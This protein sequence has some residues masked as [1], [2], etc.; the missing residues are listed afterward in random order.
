MDATLW[1][2]LWPHEAPDG[3]MSLEEARLTMIRHAHC[4][5]DRCRRKAAARD[6]LTTP[7]RDGSAS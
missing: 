7:A 1:P 5:T 4:G 2:P 6:V 3:D